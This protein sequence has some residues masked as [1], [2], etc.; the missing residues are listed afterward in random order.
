MIKSDFLILRFIMAITISCLL[1][2]SC[3]DEKYDFNKISFDF[4]LEP[5]VVAPVAYG[6]LTI[7]KFLDKYDPND[8]IREELDKSL[9][10]MYADSFGS[11]PAAEIISIPDQYFNSVNFNPYNDIAAELSPQTGKDLI[12]R[13][14]VNQRFLFSQNL[15]PDSLYI[16]NS[17]LKV[18]INSTLRQGGTLIITFPTI[19]GNNGLPF[20]EIIPVSAYPQNPD[21]SIEINIENVTIIL[22]NNF[23]PDMTVLPVIYDLE[24][25]DPP[26]G[27]L[28]D[29]NC[30]LTLSFTDIEYGTIFGAAGEYEIIKN[31]NQIRLNLFDLYYAD[32]GDLYFFNP[33]FCFDITNSFGVPVK[34]ELWDILSISVKNTISTGL[35]IREGNPFNIPASTTPGTSMKTH[36]VFD[37]HNTNIIEVTDIQPNL[38]IFNSKASLD[39]GIQNINNTFITDSSKI[40]IRAHVKLPLWMKIKDMVFDDT[41][42]FDMENII[43]EDADKFVDHL[44]ISIEAENGIP[45][46]TEFQVYLTDENYTYIDSIFNEE[47]YSFPAAKVDREG[48][49]LSKTSFLYEKEF[50]GDRIN[51][52]KNVKFAI[53]SAKLKTPDFDENRYVKFFSFYVID[54]KIKLKAD[55]IIDSNDL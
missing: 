4:R 44:K 18:H 53:A 54:Y 24:I 49:L 32:K 35:V 39:P 43:I 6:S 33:S 27:F 13:K 14:S 50:S 34:V 48:N 37:K 16:K 41:I 30:S 36:I 1:L 17:I 2:N 29:E 11:H 12:F 38:L 8:N 21:Q 19:I 20:S 25:D 31:I 28:S 23:A 22:D 51:K 47:N 55:M 42:D 7:K 10:I 45:V 52:L 15:H 40:N 26:G 5:K 3:M 9:Y 46:E